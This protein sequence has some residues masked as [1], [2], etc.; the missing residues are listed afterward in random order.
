V[1]NIYR[2]VI[3]FAAVLLA[4]GAARA[5]I[6][7]ITAECD[8]CHGDNGIS[9][10]GEIPTIAGLSEFVLS[11]TMLTFRDRARPCREIEFPDG[12]AAHAPTSMCDEAGELSDA[13]IEALAKHYAAQAF[14]PAQ[15][16]FDA[17]RAEAGA[18]IHREKCEKC[19]TDG[20]S[21]PDDDAGILAG[22][23]RPYLE[24]A[25]ADYDSGEREVLDEKMQEKLDEL[26]AEMIDALL[27]YYASQ[28]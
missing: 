11:D 12:D 10:H 9:E 26:D 27:N 13:D 21:N 8:Q 20:G 17:A 2:S 18:A 4:C 1:H 16:E 22:Q 5:D 14:V 23:W 19:H 7:E 28:Q 6:S 25:F 15:Q 3:F 24:Q